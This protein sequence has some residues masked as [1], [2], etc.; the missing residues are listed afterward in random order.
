MPD[1]SSLAIDP[2]AEAGRIEAFLRQA[3]LGTLRRRGVVIGLSGGVDSSVVAC[4]CARALGPER[5]LALLM[6]E[7]ESSSQSLTLGW[8][9]ADHL[10]IRALEE[11]IGG[12]LEAAGCYARHDE[13]IRLVF[14][15]YEPGWRFKV[16]I[17]SASQEHRLNVSTLTIELPSGETK[18]ARMP[19]DAYLGLV[20]AMNFKQR[21]R[22]MMEYYHA[23]R[24]HYA[25]AGTP[26]RMEYDQGFFV[27][28][29]DGAADLKPIAHLYKTQVYQLARHLGVP[30][31]VLRQTPTTDT[32][33]MPQTQEE[34]YFGLP[35]QQMDLCLYGRN[36]GVPAEAVAA[37]AGLTPEQV[38]RVYADIDQKRRSTRY[39]H[40]RP[41]VVEPVTET[42]D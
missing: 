7:R 1:T 17:R 8:L 20:A 12:I 39:L 40:A 22:K 36:H 16:T 10:G 25:V 32:Y 38:E 5:V 21:T 6:P 23:D 2:I 18:T 29:G 9:V 33:P 34:F 31:I 35:Y 3:V 14:P 37:A 28:Q 42:T 4:L 15:E 13:A 26:N 30:E 24:L 19:L 27:K 41:Q 11:P